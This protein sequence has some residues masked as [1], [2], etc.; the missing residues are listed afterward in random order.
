MTGRQ[1]L[2]AALLVLL[3]GQA[4]LCAILPGT[5]QLTR[6]ENGLPIRWTTSG[7][8]A[9]IHGDDGDLFITYEKSTRQWVLI[10]QANDATAATDG[11]VPRLMANFGGAGASNML[12]L[13]ARKVN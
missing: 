6:Y 7:T 10:L 4:A 3:I 5:I 2:F 9:L 8:S 1:Y 11:R 12:Y 13:E